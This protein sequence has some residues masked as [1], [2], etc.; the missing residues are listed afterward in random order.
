MNQSVA[1]RIA[2]SRT[3]WAGN[4]TYGAERFVAPTTVEEAQEAVRASTK[5]RAVGTR[6]CFNDIADTDGTHISLENLNRVVS[7]DSAN[8]RVTVEGGIKY[9]EI[10]PYL[11]ER[12]FALHNTASLPHIS[13]AGACATATHGSGALGNLAVAVAE[14]QFIDGAGDLVS[15][16]RAADGDTFAGAVVNLGALGVVT[17]FTLDLQPAFHVRQDVFRGLPIA[18]LADH[19]DEIVSSGY[20]VSTFTVWQSDDIEQVWIKSAIR[21]D[22]PFIARSD[23][24]GARPAT[25][26]LHPMEGLDAIHCTEQMGVPGAAHERLPHFRAGF[27]PASGDEL[28]VEYFVPRTHATGAIRALR[29]HG[30]LFKDIL[31]GG[32]IRTIAADDFWMS[33]CYGTPCVAFHFSF[34]QDWPA[35][36]TILPK[37]ETALAPF[38]P[39]PHWGKLFTMSPKR[40]QAQYPRLSDFKALIQAHDPHGKFRNRFV[41]RTL[42]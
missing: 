26:N 17:K 29:S 11:H 28:Q 41:D 39:R 34:R 22:A 1:P 24:F 18:A 9:G 36:K 4:L 42:F 33:P 14:L 15:L 6:H 10:G 23:L 13:V 35:L 8:R 7:V 31:V 40:I 32:E 12:G 37:V 20:S 25:Q 19:F 21:A 27:T 30:G 16:S 5:V 38:H 3:N 2:A